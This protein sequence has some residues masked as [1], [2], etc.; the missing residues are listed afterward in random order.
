MRNSIAI[1]TLTALLM[2]LVI[3][4]GWSGGASSA[5]DRTLIQQAMAVRADSPG[6]AAAATIV[7]ALGGAAVT[8]SL[9]LVAAVALLLRRQPHRA[10][11]LILTVLGERA[12]VNGLKAWMGRP[13]P[14]DGAFDV[15]SMAFP[16]GHAAHSMTVF[17]MV[18]L[19]L[20]PQPY[21]RPA[22]VVAIAC[23]LVVGLT[24]LLLGVHWPSDVLA[25]WAVGLIAVMPALWHLASGRDAL[26]AKHEVVG[27]HGNPVRED[28]AT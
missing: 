18:A 17:V 6:L 7:T 15:S 28:E 16:S 12:L 2:V 9:M 27:R 11:W 25:G 10:L 26:E 8:L 13:R 21:R 20:V 4:V 3:T 24:R 14:V 1:G 22:V 5:F 19:L 23:S